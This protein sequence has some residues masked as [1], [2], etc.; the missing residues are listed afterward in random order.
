MTA[1]PRA[2]L[3][4]ETGVTLADDRPLGVGVVFVRDEQ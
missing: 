2:L 1:V 4:R 3:L